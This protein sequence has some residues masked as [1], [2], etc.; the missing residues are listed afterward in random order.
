MPQRGQL[1]RTVENRNE[2]F[3]LCLF[4]SLQQ[5]RKSGAVES[6]RRAL[7]AQQST[8]IENPVIKMEPVHG[9][10]DG[11]RFAALVD[12]MEQIVGN[13][14]FSGSRRACDGHD[15]ALVGFRQPRKNFRRQGFALNRRHVRFP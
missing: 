12:G 15:Q 9:H 13:G 2:D 7:A 10:D 1:Q 14:G 11:R 8:L 3:A 6:G 4:Q 5:H